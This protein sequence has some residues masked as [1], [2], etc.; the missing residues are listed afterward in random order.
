MEIRCS[1]SPFLSVRW[2]CA[3]EGNVIDEVVFENVNGNMMVV[4]QKINAGSKDSISAK[5]S[6]FNQIFIE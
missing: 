1:L 2:S 3:D 5:N 6:S 4:Y